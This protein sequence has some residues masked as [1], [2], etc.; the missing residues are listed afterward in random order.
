MRLLFAVL[1]LVVTFN[2]T[3]A[4]YYVDPAGDDTKDGVSEKSAWRSVGH[5]NA[6]TFAPGDKILFR[7]GGEWREALAPNCS[8]AADKPITF[9]AFGSGP[10]PKFWGSDLLP[11]DKWQAESNGVYVFKGLKAPAVTQV[12]ANHGTEKGGAWFSAKPLAAPGAFEFRNGEL[13]INSQSDP[14]T[15][16]RIY[17]AILRQDVVNS[18][19]KDHLV[20]KN[21]VGDE[22][23]DPANGYVI[24]VMGSS[25]VIVEDCEAY[26]GG[27]HNIGVINSTG[28]VVRRAKTG[29]AIPK[30]D[31]GATFFV[32]YAGAESKYSGC[33]C[34][35]IDCAADHFEDGFG[36]RYLYFVC[37]GEKMGPLSFVNPID[38]GGKFSIL[39]DNPAQV[40]TV[41]GGTIEDA[42][43]ELFCNKATIDGVTFT[44]DASIDCYGCDNVFQNM[45]MQINPKGGGPTGYG[46]AIVLRDSALRSTIRFNTIVMDKAAP[47]DKS[48]LV[49]LNVHQ[50]VEWYGNI[51]QST[52]RVVH[53]WNGAISKENVKR[54]DYNLYNPNATFGSLKFADWKA[55]NFGDANSKEAASKFVNAEKG[56]LALDAGSPAID[57]VPIKDVTVPANDFDGSKRPLGAAA[58]IGAFE[59]TP[60][61][62]TAEATQH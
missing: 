37:H 8:G 6:T 14:R 50:P 4:T 46:A 3:A 29:Y 52:G 32:T 10:K 57:A 35:W 28:I 27:R 31:G 61:R 20:F 25:D 56:N 21:L 16:G 59:F 9:D 34:Q 60:D 1:T 40:V 15:D 41:T 19:G 5:V 11:S 62:R 51:L 58:D 47:Q 18:N 49:F 38:H 53:N 12:L 26:R 54:A 44:G 22:C 23:A 42:D 17:A 55:L 48:C 43:F 7:R 36:G 24:R 33:T 2:A 39:Q 13:R 45:K 30:L